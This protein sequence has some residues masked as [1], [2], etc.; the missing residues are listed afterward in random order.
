MLPNQRFIRECVAFSLFVLWVVLLL[1]G[2]GC[3]S[4]MTE[5][6]RFFFPIIT[7]L[8]LISSLIFWRSISLSKRKNARRS[9]KRRSRKR[10]G[11]AE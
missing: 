2:L 8:V 3:W 4:L 7:I 10:G 1:I 5:L 9:L 11:H 6:E